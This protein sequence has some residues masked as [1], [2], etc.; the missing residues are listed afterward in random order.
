[1]VFSLIYQ[2]NSIMFNSLNRVFKTAEDFGEV[3]D[4]GS[5]SGRWVW[6]PAQ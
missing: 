6:N 5:H 1:M 4:E 3:C 2:L